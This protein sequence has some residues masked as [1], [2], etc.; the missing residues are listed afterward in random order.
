MPGPRSEFTQEIADAIC[1][2]MADG[3]SVRE[4]C[5]KDEMPA[6]STVFKWLS[7]QPS[8]VEQY[9]RAREAQADYM[10]EEILEICDDGSNDWMERQTDAGTITMPDHEHI[11]RSKLRVDTRRWL[12]SKLQPKKYGEKVA[13]TGGDGGPIL[14][15]TG[16]IRKTDE[17]P[18]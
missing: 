8:F 4:I 14:M 10:A 2:Y 1:G 18:A 6:M 5:R 3:M 17:D 16:V 12:M 13:L 15:A 9:A 7:Q 11:N